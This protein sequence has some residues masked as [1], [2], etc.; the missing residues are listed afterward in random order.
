M[1]LLDSPFPQP[2]RRLP[3]LIRVSS[4]AKKQARAEQAECQHQ[5]NAAM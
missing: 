2:A 3:S 4:P 1:R 5:H